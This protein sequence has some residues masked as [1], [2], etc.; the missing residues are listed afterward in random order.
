[1]KMLFALVASIAVAAGLM[2]GFAFLVGTPVRAQAFDMSMPGPYKI[3]T[4]CDTLADVEAIAKLRNEGVTMS[5]AVRQVNQKQDDLCRIQ[6]T[7][8]TPGALET[9]VLILGK[10]YEVHSIRILGRMRDFK[11]E[12]V[13]KSSG[14]ALVLA[15]AHGI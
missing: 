11:L 13:G 9:R 5:E 2:I 4:V 3:L 15:P 1:M 12:R 10:V 6:A 14:F 8:F 7:V